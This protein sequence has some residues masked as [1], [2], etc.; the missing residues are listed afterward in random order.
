MRETSGAPRAGAHACIA[1]ARCCAR[2]RSRR[3]RGDAHRDP[4]GRCG[5]QARHSRSPA[6]FRPT[7]RRGIVPRHEYTT[8]IAGRA[9]HDPRQHARERHAVAV[10]V[11]LAVPPPD[12]LERGPVARSRASASIRA[13]HG[14]HPLRNHRCRRGR[15]GGEQPQRESLTGVQWR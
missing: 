8:T 12:D 15:T 10:R 14:V 9:A 5:G 7:C 2:S 6:A 4:V 13:A 3:P 11:M 1:L